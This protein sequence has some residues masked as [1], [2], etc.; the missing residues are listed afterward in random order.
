MSK[1]KFNPNELSK[2]NNPERL[3]ILNLFDIIKHYNLEDVNTFV[4]LGIG[5]GLYT[6]ELLKLLPSAKG[7]GLD[8]STEMLEWVKQNVIPNNERLKVFQMDENEIPLDDESVDLVFMVTVH[9]ELDD[10]ISI[11]KEC[12]RVLKPGGT[13]FIAD[14]INEVKSNPYSVEDVKEQLEQVGYK[15][16]NIY[17]GSEKFFCIG[18]VK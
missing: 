8:I 16:I 4:D 14:W 6:K 11:I 13:V 3:K 10:P 17:D 2:L 12:K 15:L 18:A 5:T 7:I 9:H 1:H